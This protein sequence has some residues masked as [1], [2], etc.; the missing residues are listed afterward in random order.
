M[1]VNECEQ[2]KS[3]HHK[4]R[5]ASMNEILEYCS[6]FD[7]NTWDKYTNF[8]KW[9]NS[10]NLNDWDNMVDDF[11]QLYSNQKENVPYLA[12]NICTYHR[13]NEVQQNIHKLLD[14]KFF[15][16]ENIAFYGHLH[17]FVTDNGSELSLSDDE[18]LHI[19]H[20]Q[21]TGGSGGFQKGLEWIRNS[22][23]PFTHVIFM[24]D[25]IEFDV[26]TFYK[27]YIFLSYIKKEYEDYPIAGRMFRKDKPYIQDTAAEIWNRGD[28]RHVG[29]HLD[30]RDTVNLISVNDNTG[31]EYG[32]F[33]FCCYPM[34]F[35]RENDIMP[36][37]IH[38]DDVEYGLRCGR[39]PIILNGV[40]V[41][42]ETYEY[43]QSPLMNYY[44]TRNP[45][46][47]NEKYHLLPKPQIMLDT[48]K[49]KITEFHV[50]KDFASEYYIILGMYDFLKGINWL[51]KVNSCKKHTRLQKARISKYK[52]AFLWR[53]AEWKL[54]RKYKI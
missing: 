5:M 3:V 43:R 27:L 37:F 36:F 39:I 42:H 13:L 41:W 40:Q 7:Y 20:N 54:K 48:W 38:C 16:Q 24:D 25:D 26:E 53:M 8:S 46:F 4:W 1:S 30:M 33:W 11:E 51:Y 47:V 10:K 31:A 6:Y 22:R 21:N 17:I 44:D 35:A 23:V 9:D 28:I 34:S 12:I 29:Y 49:E 45:L 18:F 2:T 15:E 19:Q 14:S 50:K 32:G 52:N